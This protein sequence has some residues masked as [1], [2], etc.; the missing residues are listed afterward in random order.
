M[1]EVIGAVISLGVLLKQTIVDPLCRM[2]LLVP[3]LA[4]LFQ[5]L[6]DGILVGVQ[7]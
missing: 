4:V 2:L 7:F 5:P 1:D 6:I 3:V